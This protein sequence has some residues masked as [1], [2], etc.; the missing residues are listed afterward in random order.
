MR[1]FAVILAV[2]GLLS[3]ST[4]RAELPIVK[5]KGRGMV[6][7][8]SYYSQTTAEFEI[9]YRDESLPWGSQVSVIYGFGGL[10][11]SPVAAGMGARLD[12]TDQ[13][14]KASEAVAPYTWV[15]RFSQVI[16]SRYSSRRLDQLQFVLRISLPQGGDRY[17]RG[18][19]TS[20]GFIQAEFPFL[21]KSPCLDSSS[22]RQ[23]PFVDLSLSAVDRL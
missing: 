1:H 18:G 21:G 23:L 4:V 12:W 8:C 15:S 6:S 14:E 9:W 7:N 11:Q 10:D 22:D 17:F 3:T 20:M 2:I 16:H 5:V 19:Q 13:S